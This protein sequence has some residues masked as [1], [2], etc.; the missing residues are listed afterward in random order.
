MLIQFDFATTEKHF[1][2]ILELQRQNLI[3]TLSEEQQ[4]REGFVFA[5]HT[6][7]VLKKMATHLPQVVA[8][9]EGKVV[10]YNLAMLSAMRDTLP[11]LIPMFDE[12]EKSQYKGRPLREYKFIVGGQ[13]CVSREFR[14]QGLL[15]KLYHA[16]RDSLPQDYQLCVTEI[17][18][19]NTVSLNA[20]KKMGF[21]TI[22]S[23]FDGKTQW[24]I[25]AWELS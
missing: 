16:T 8:F 24:D 25:V 11:S 3:G 1:E 7:S 15:K 2:Q 4:A 13:V 5:E 20:H 9:H 17:A 23:Y 18:V 12:F 6:L 14:G 10:G 22:R 21:E 19:N